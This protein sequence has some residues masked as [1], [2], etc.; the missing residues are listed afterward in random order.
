M[1]YINSLKEKSHTVVFGDGKIFDKIQHK[2]LKQTNKKS[3]HSPTDK[4]CL[5]QTCKI[6]IWGHFH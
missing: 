2:F 3:T 1:D 4:E 5:V 6:P